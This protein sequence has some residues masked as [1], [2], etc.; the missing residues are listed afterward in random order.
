MGQTLGKFLLRYSGKVTIRLV[1]STKDKL[2]GTFAVTYT[3]K[4]GVTRLAQENSLRVAVSNALRAPRRQG[5][6]RAA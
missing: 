6:R 5:L 3:P 4:S 1:N 2:G